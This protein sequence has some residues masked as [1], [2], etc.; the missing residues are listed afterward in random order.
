MAVGGRDRDA[1]PAPDLVERKFTAT[2]PNQLWVADITYVPTWSGFLFVAIVLD[3]YSRN[4]LP[5][6][7]ALNVPPVVPP[8]GPGLPPGRS[9]GPSCG[10]PWSLMTKRPRS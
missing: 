9:L 2:A 8:A 10:R 1:R 7:P 4:I 3:V 5:F 6:L